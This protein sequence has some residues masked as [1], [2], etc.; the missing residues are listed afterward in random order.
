MLLPDRESLRKGYFELFAEEEGG[1]LLEDSG[2]T[3]VDFLRVR[4]VLLEVFF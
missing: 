3:A 4:V 2:S 1:E